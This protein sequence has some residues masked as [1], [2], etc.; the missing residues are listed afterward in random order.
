MNAFAAGGENTAPNAFGAN[1]AGYLRVSYAA[2]ADD[3]E[4]ALGRIGAF[5]DRQ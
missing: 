5:L 1:G 4:Q 2:S 3:I